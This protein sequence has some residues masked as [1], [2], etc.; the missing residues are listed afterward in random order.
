MFREENGLLESA[1]ALKLIAD[2]NFADFDDLKPN[3]EQLFEHNHNFSLASSQMRCAV[4][5]ALVR[6]LKEYCLSAPLLY[7]NPSTSFQEKVERHRRLIRDSEEGCPSLRLKNLFRICKS[8]FAMPV[9]IPFEHREDENLRFEHSTFGYVLREIKFECD[10]NRSNSRLREAFDALFRL[11][12]EMRRVGIQFPSGMEREVH[13]YFPCKRGKRCRHCKICTTV[14][15]IIGIMRDHNFR[16]S[17]RLFFQ[18][19]FQGK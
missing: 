9:G 8:W 15:R 7:S 13:E 17:D 14:S 3:P 5:A 1:L 2:A 10:K 16:P 19:T 4:Q 12:T 11:T 6:E 18:M